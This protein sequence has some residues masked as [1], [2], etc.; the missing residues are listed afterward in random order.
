MQIFV[1]MLALIIFGKFYILKFVNIFFSEYE[2]RELLIH[3][4]NEQSV[5]SYNRELQRL[6]YELDFL[7]SEDKKGFKF[8]NIY[9]CKLQL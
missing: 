7:K 5:N 3:E 6:Q 1:Q 8:Y 2:Q 4:E 9:N